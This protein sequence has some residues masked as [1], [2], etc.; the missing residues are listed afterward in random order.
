MDMIAN[1]PD[2]YGDTAHFA[3]NSADVGEHLSE[4]LVAYLHAVVLDMEDDMDVV[5]C[6]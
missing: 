6:E 3:D 4:V 5:S 1:A 2:L